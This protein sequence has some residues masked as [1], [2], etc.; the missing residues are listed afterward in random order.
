MKNVARARVDSF[1]NRYLDAAM[2]RLGIQ[3]DYALADRLGVTPQAISKMRGGGAMSNTTAVRIAE[4]LDID[5]IRVI[6]ESEIERGA[7]QVIWRRIAQKATACALLAVG[8]GAAPSPAPAAGA[9]ASPQ[10]YVKRRRP[11]GPSGGAFARAALQLLG[12]RPPAYL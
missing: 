7:D 4:I 3:S 11:R 2:A 1:T 8:I 9:D 5:P 6:A 12:L 10:Y